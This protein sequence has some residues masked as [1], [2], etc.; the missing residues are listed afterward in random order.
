MIIVW[1]V[2]PHLENGRSPLTS[3]D[4]YF[5]S[6]LRLLSYHP[7]TATPEKICC[8]CYYFYLWLWE[9]LQSVP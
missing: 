9:K 2:V 1:K 4:S 3:L 7:S 8:C 5:F 6:D